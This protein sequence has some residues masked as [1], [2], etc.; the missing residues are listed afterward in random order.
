VEDKIRHVMCPPITLKESKQETSD[1]SHPSSNLHPPTWLREQELLFHPALWM[2]PCLEQTWWWF[3]VSR[4][5]WC[6][7]ILWVWSAKTKLC[8]ETCD[9]HIMD[10]HNMLMMKIWS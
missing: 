2:I 8:C 9:H 5:W 3:H 10:H 1:H 4:H 7:W 6:S